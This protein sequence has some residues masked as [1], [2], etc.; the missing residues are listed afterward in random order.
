MRRETNEA[1]IT[2]SNA[3]MASGTVTFGLYSSSQCTPGS[4]V[5]TSTNRLVGNP[6][7]SSLADSDPVST[8]LNPGTYY[9]TAAYG[10]DS[11]NQPSSSG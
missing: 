8:Q 6:G 9:W 11:R 1:T 10:G 7:P 2:G 3:S 4:Q 5:F